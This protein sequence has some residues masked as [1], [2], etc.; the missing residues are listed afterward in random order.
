MYPQ[1]N[2]YYTAQAAGEAR[3]V[4]KKYTSMCSDITKE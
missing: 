3:Q 4:N 2:E 1:E